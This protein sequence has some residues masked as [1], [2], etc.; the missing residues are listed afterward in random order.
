MTIAAVAPGL[1]SANQ[2]GAGVAAADAF[3]I[4]ASNRRVNQSVF[5][6]HPPAA[7]S[8]LGTPLSLGGAGDTLYV[9]LYGTGIRGATV[10][11]CFVGG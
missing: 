1:F 10:V 3:L 8:C 5:A 4:T 6:C 9:E 11:Q 2:D 7:R